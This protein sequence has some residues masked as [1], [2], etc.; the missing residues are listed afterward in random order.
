[1]KT[2]PIYHERRVMVLRWIEA[3]PEH[4][5]QEAW[6][7]GTSHCYAGVAEMMRLNLDPREH[8]PSGDPAVTHSLCSREK[9]MDWLGF[10][11]GN[12]CDE[13][14]FDWLTRSA[15]TLSDIRERI[16]FLSM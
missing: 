2:N 10:A 6:H 5:N 8:C 3:H 1:M 16:E 12:W 11:P 9:T 7:C 15:N 13:E 14:R 4:W